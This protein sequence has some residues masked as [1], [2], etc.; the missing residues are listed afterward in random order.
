MSE[1]SE[2]NILNVT[3]VL[4]VSRISEKNSSGARVNV[5]KNCETSGA[6]TNK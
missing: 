6:C 5:L 2:I 1:I 4:E 3:D